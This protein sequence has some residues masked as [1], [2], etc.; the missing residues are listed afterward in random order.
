MLNRLCRSIRPGVVV[1]LAL[2]AAAC[3]DSDN[4]PQQVDSVNQYTAEVVWTEYGIPHVTAQDWGSL[5]YGVGY[6][7]ARENFCTL[8]RE[9][10]FSAG[11]SAMYLG[12]EGDFDSDLVMKLYNS[13][14]AVA[15][16]I[17]EQFHDEV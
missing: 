1:S 5:G 8:M 6:A 3:S 15:R 2:F 14:A 10:V 4:A 7:Y 11:N 16:M 17:D 9:Y 13:D 12:D